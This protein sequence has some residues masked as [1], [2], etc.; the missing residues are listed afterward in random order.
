MRR[1]ELAACADR[2]QLRVFGELLNANQ[3]RIEKGSLCTLMRELLRQ[4]RR[5]EHCAGP[6]AEPER[7]LTKVLQEYR[8]A[9]TAEGNAQKH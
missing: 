3:H 1:E 5:C 9:K 8:K 2:E 6:G 4:Q 7:E